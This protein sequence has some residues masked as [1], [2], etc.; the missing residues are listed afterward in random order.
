MLCSGRRWITH[1]S[2]IIGRFVLAI[3][4]EWTPARL[5]AQTGFRQYRL[6]DA[7]KL[8]A[9]GYRLWPTETF[10]AGVPEPRNAVHYDAVV[11]WD[12]AS[13]PPT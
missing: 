13:S 6:A 7:S 8:S 11:A 4:D 10:V 5:A 9:A 3:T 2:S 1:I 12:L